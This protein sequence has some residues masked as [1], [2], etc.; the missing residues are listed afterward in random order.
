MNCVWKAVGQV[1]S[2]SSH[3]RGGIRCQDA[4]KW[5]TAGDNIAMAVADGH[6]GHKH[7]RSDR[8]AMLAVEAAC[9]RLLNGDEGRIVPAWTRAIIE[10]LKRDPLSKEEMD[11][12]ERLEG[13]MSR[14]AVENDPAIAYG[15]TLVAVL[16]S[17]DR[18]MCFQIGDGD[19]LFVHQDGSVMQPLAYD[20][21]SAANETTSLAM[22][23]AQ[24]EARVKRVQLR[25]HDPA[26]ILL[27]TDGYEGS[28][29]GSR[30][31]FLKI[32]PDYLDLI[33]DNGIESVAAALEDILA[34][35]SRLGSG[36]DITL[37]ILS[38]A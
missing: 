6:G 14:Q 23:D 34:E 21:C 2:G 36:D 4:I 30:D 9:D 5:S 31:D 12:V 33:R 35:T 22:P 38:R 7:F 10:D 29:P 8:G 17:G 18:A 37:G 32:G 25:E 15:T 13:P 16:A 11:A 26:L 19:I 28:F 1:V 3:V 27:S 24:K 20:G